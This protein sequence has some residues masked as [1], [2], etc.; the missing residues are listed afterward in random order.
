LSF[1]YRLYALFINRENETALYRQ[2][3]GTLYI[4][5]AFKAGLTVV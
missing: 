3:F 5:V 1:I 4:E 2:S